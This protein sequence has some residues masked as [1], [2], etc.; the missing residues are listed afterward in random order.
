MSVQFILIVVGA[1]LLG[2][3]PS[4]YLAAKF[5]RRIDLR[6]FGTGNIGASNVLRATSKW[7]TIPVIIFDIGKGM[8]PVF[9]AQRLGMG[10]FQQVASGVAVI[11]GHNWSVFLRFNGGRGILATLG[12][13]LILT[14]RSAISVVIMVL[15][16]A[17]FH[18]TAVGVLIAVVFLSVSSWFFTPAGASQPML[19]LGFV[20]IL[21]IAVLRRLTAARSPLADSVS[22]AELFTSRLLFDRDIRDREVWRKYSSS[23]SETS[24]GNKGQADK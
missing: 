8:L 23:M 12:V 21:A 13:A 4:A 15:A 10:T 17:I 6:Q 1:Y 19:T 9:L 5:S 3:V 24:Q 20:A 7:T 22:K 2:S 16:F 11:I 14:P 18:Q